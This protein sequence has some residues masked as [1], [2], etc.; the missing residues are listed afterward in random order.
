MTARDRLLA[1]ALESFLDLGYTAA[2]TREISRRAGVTE[3][4]LFNQFPTKADLLREAVAGAI[5]EVPHEGRVRDR[6]DVRALRHETDVASFLTAFAAITSEVHRRSARLAELTRQAAAAD[7][8]AADLWAWG[9]VEQERDVRKVLTVM[10]ERAWLDKTD[11]RRAVD[12][13]VVLTGHETYA[14]LCLERG[15]SLRRYRTWLQRHLAADL[16]Q[17]RHGQKPDR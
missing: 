1:A 13:V 14:Q 9:K 16:D 3:R 8:G 10:V 4:T 17:P 6:D 11:L 12:T 5:A 15:W 7:P 2:S